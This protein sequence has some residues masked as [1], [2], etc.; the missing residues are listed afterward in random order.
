MNGVWPADPGVYARGM[1]VALLI[2]AVVAAQGAEVEA[3]R[4]T[5]GGHPLEIQVPRPSFSEMGKSSA[6]SA[7]P[8]FTGEIAVRAPPETIRRIISDYGLRE[9]R[10]VGTAA[11][12]AAAIGGDPHGPLRALGSLGQDPWVTWSEPVATQ[13]HRVRSVPTDPHYGLQWQLGAAT[14]MDLE[15]VWD[16]FTGT[17]IRIAIVDSGTKTSH[18][19]LTANCIAGWDLLSSDADPSPVPRG[20]GYDTERKHGTWTAGTAAA[21]RNAVGGV[22]VAYGASIIPI[23]AIDD[24]LTSA[25]TADAL[26]WALPGHRPPGAPT[27]EPDVNSNSWGPSDDGI[28]HGAVAEGPGSLELD[29]LDAATTD[30]RGGKGTVIVFACGNGGRE[31]PNGSLD[32]T[33]WD[34]CD[35]DGYAGNRHVIAVGSTNFAGKRSEYSERGA[36]LFISAPVGDTLITPDSEDDGAI[37][38]TY[39]GSAPTGTDGYMTVLGTS[40]AAPEV[41]GVVALMLEANPALTWRDVRHILAETATRNDDSDANWITNG[42]NLHWNLNYGFGVVDALAAVTAA[43]TWTTVPAATV[44][45]TAAYAPGSPLAIP[46]NGATAPIALSVTA[47]PRFR[48]E[49]AELTIDANHPRQGDLAFT[50]ISPRGTTVT[51]LAR[52]R[53]TA[54]A[55]V[56]TLTSVATWNEWP[57]G[58]W[59]LVARDVASGSSGFLVSAHLTVHGYLAASAAAPGTATAVGSSAVYSTKAGASA[60]PPA[61]GGG[62]TG[63]ASD[64]GGGSACGSG[65]GIAVLLMSLIGARLIRRRVQ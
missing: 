21:A 55:R 42:A 59:R 37:V 15:P 20:D 58:D 62:S 6:S 3:V 34:T 26:G 9:V 8:G 40:F 38:P 60:P 39:A 45:L 16:S 53:D 50:L 17:G 52:P 43:E 2:L 30:G 41:A 27:T 54:A 7:I 49:W 24:G 25:M 29:A 31:V 46:D 56:W 22:G 65:S 47:D 19:D 12:L 57:D 64:G 18:E 10:V 48:A 11:L 51:F 44:P 4:T 36:C 32:R 28:D 35:R 63:S 1:R 5:Y 13:R 14:G 61:G 33:Y 23:R